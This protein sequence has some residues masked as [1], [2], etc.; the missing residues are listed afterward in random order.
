MRRL[1][2]GAIHP[3]GEI[4]CARAPPERPGQTGLKAKTR[5]VRLC[6]L[7]RCTARRRFAKTPHAGL[8][9]LASLKG[10]KEKEALNPA[11]IGREK[12]AKMMLKNAC[13]NPPRQ[14]TTREKLFPPEQ[15]PETATLNRRRR[16]E[17]IHGR[18]PPQGE[19]ATRGAL[20]L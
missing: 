18:K 10:A 13:K 3:D 15:S 5:H 9:V 2:K 20:Y 8:C 7:S 19:N 1:L 6:T 4:A 12:R 16:Y 14:A 11:C 17:N